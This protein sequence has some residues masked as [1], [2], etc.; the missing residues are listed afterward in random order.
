MGEWFVDSLR[1]PQS[2]TYVTLRRIEV[3]PLLRSL[4]WLPVHQRVTLKL[5]TLAH[6]QWRFWGFHFG[7]PLGWRHFHL[8][9][10]TTNRPTFA[11]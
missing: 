10:H 8:R 6:K 2:A 5:A 1:Y 9:G 3:L 4:H 7:G 11:L